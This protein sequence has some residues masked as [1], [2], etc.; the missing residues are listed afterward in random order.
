MAR[1]WKAKG[2]EAKALADPMSKI[3]LQLQSSLIQSD[4]RG[5]LCGC[6]VLLAAEQE[7]AH[8]LGRAY[9]GNRVINAEKDKHWFQLDMEEAFFLCYSLKCLK[10]AGEDKRPKDVQEL[11]QHMKSKKAAFP[12][13]YKAYSHLRLKN[14]VVR[15][16]FKYGA[17][18]VAYR[19]HPNLVH[20][21]YAVLVSSEG[22]G[23]ANGRLR[24][25]SDFIHGTLRLCLGVVKTLL[26]L[27]ISKNGHDA[28]SPS[29]LENY[30][31]DERT[32]SRW[33]PEQGRED[34]TSVDVESQVSQ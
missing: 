20:S 34:D 13:F 25:W 11:W 23:E 15:P 1:K 19:H 9:F 14:W 30:T 4:A 5:I 22:D 10:I 17:D 27:S 8:L 31:V 18:F 24:V 2:A 6:S 7:Q 12:D 29:C 32:V 3:V 16:G 21:D 28:A 33:V 26:V